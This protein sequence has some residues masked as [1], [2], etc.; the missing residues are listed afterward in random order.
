MLNIADGQEAL[1]QNVLEA[2]E[3]NFSFFTVYM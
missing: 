1:T 3:Y 2:D